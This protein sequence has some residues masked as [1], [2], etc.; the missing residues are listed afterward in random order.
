MHARVLSAVRYSIR[1]KLMFVVLATTAVALLLTGT[2]MVLHDLRTYHETWINDL[3][4]QANLIGSASA[5]ALQFDDVKVARENLELLKLR[6][7]ISAAAIYT[8]RGTLFATY[9]RSDRKDFAFPPLPQ[10]DG[11]AV[12]GREIALFKR[13]ESNN[14]IL[15]TIYFRARYELIERLSSYLVILGAVMLTGLVVAGFMAAWLQGSLLSPILSMT[16][17]ARQ[18][19]TRRDFSL[20]VAKTTDDEIGYLVDT[21]NSMLAEIGRRAQALEESNVSLEHEMAER[22][23]AQDALS[24]ADKRKDEFLA[25]L[26][27]ELRNP[28]APLRN[29]LEIVRTS[30][31]DPKAVQDARDMMER[32]LR[33]LVHLVND[34]LDV[35]RITTGKMT[36]KLERT[37]LA[38]VIENALEM[39]GPLVRAR[40]HALVVQAPKEPAMLEVDATRIAQV[41][42]NLLNNASKFTDPGGRIT[43]VAQV[44]GNEL[45][46]T[47]SDTGIGIAPEMQPLIFDMF[48]QADRSLEREQAGLGVGLS[49]ARHLVEMH[50]GSIRASSA[51]L[52]QGSAFVV[53]LPC[54]VESRLDDVGRTLDMAPADAARGQRV[55]LADDNVD[56]AES[57]SLIL[58]MSGH[59][60]HVANDGAAAFDMAENFIPD[61]AFL[62][63][64]LPKINGYDL[65]RRLREIP[66]L[67]AC[68][69]VAVTGWGQEDDRRK[70]REAGFDHH[71]VKP[72]EPEQI[73]EAIATYRR[74]G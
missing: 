54:V 69:F 30:G 56:F 31:N 67:K 49:L 29:A 26:A 43:F 5:P 20:R 34:L 27:H 41:F 2:S 65:A 38:S 62:D 55:L 52:G 66:A 12:E 61:F 10:A 17:V 37:P 6:P 60:V 9:D 40:Q 18:V 11:Y 1:R 7:R 72:V 13:I 33:Q 16:D 46:V 36:L 53:N 58:Q 64:G 3:F 42:V 45:T 74:A 50:R 14:E 48:A 22:R 15:G 68:V 8:A 28:L 4:V 21:F 47:V 35:S 44:H 23:V 71:L 39:A 24:I 70:A 32:Q 51:G 19:M 59:E 57:L 63:I 25:T 73:L